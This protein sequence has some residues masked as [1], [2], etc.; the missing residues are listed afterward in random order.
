MPATGWVVAKT[1]RKAILEEEE[2]MELKRIVMVAVVGL[3]AACS[4]QNGSTVGQGEESREG[5]T[6]GSSTEIV[7]DTTRPRD[8]LDRADSG[9]GGPVQREFG[10]FQQQPER[11]ALTSDKELEKSVRVMLTTGSVGTTGVIAENMLTDIQVQSENGVV[12]LS[13][14]VHAAGEKEIIEKQV[15]GMKGVKDV[16]NNLEV[17]TPHQDHRPLQP[18]IGPND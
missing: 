16:V 1:G 8:N 14:A 15:R 2:G 9:V 11:E 4:Q 10:N 18:R 13:G 5:Q 17:T 12:T 7:T 6:Y 3:A